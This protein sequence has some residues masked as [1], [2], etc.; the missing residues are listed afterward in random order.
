MNFT[1]STGTTNVGSWYNFQPPALPSPKFPRPT[2]QFQKASR[3][4]L[5]PAC[6]SPLLTPDLTV[7][8]RVEFAVGSTRHLGA[9]LFLVSNGK[10]TME[11]K[12]RWNHPTTF[13]QLLREVCSY[14]E[15]RL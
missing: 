3:Q 6:N 14:A 10:R 4:L 12:V 15:S 11:V 8:S 2:V 5:L 7:E 9:A 1:W 13:G